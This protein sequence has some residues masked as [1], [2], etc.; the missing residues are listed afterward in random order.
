MVSSHAI[1]VLR[2]DDWGTGGAQAKAAI[3]AM[4]GFYNETAGQWQPE[5]AW[6]LSGNAL[7]ALLDYMHKTGS[8]E[9]TAQVLHTIDTQ[10]AP[11]EWWP[12]GGGYFRAD[13]TDDTGWWALA[14]CRMFDITGEYVYL[15]YAKKDEEYMRNYWSDSCGGGIIQDIRNNIYKN[16]ISNEL[17]FTLAAALHNRLPDDEVYLDHALEAW[18]WFR[19]S[20]MINS[21]H[22]VNDGLLNSCENNGGPTW[23]YN[24]GVVLGGL[25]ELYVATKEEDYLVTARQIAD[26]VLASGTLVVN[27]ILTEP[28]EAT[29][30]CNFDA[31]SFKGIFARYLGQLD[32][33]LEG[34]P[35]RA[36]LVANAQ[37]AWGTD[38][39]S[40]GYFDVRWSGPFNTSTVATQAS[41]ASLMIA[42]MVGFGV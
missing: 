13:S 18:K 22:L 3:D 32:E 21:A 23:T 42:A 30:D 11:L 37:R 12:Q 34:H 1:P 25:V 40:T 36:F 29:G 19:A 24:Q 2:Q 27:G 17:Y 39:N 7:Q 8:N 38:R 35:Y 5:I 14:M 26:A 9:Y 6:W 15:D 4:M 41:A 10:K 28:C 31:Q 20:G 16:A 33:V